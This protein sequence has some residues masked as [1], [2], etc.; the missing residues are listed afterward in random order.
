[1]SMIT[2]QMI[3]ALPSAKWTRADYD[4]H[5]ALNQTGCKYILHSPGHYKAQLTAPKKETEA[6]RIGSLTHLFVLQPDVFTSSVI[7]TPEDAPKRPTKKQI[8]AKKPKPETIEAISWWNNFEEASKGKTVAD[9]D[10]YAQ[11]VRVGQALQAELQKHKVTPLATELCLVT[12]YGEVPL[13]A[14]LDLVTADGWIWDLKTFGDYIT[15]NNV[16]KAV[17]QRHYHLQAAFY[18]QM[19][20]QVFG[21]KPKGFRLACVEKEEPCA[22]ASFQ[23]SDDLITEGQM[24]MIKAIEAYRAAT[25]FDSWPLYP[26]EIQIIT[27]RKYAGEAGQI[28]LA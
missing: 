19:F 22:T 8:E 17:Y 9:R 15:P 1:M 13:K 12:N 20:K 14:Q 23:I 3:E 16:T 24:L 25:A 27:P 18:T 5:Q 26:D 11:A 4:A 21:T 2:K 7:C 6:L 10:E 28:S